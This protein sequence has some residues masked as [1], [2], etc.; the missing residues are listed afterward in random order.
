MIK[1]ELQIK[2]K[3]ITQVSYRQVELGRWVAKELRNVW[4][5]QRFRTEKSWFSF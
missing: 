3:K 5:N 4:S 2:K 1:E